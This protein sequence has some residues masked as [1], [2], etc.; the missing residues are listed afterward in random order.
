MSRLRKGQKGGEMV[1]L[2]DCPPG[3]LQHI[4]RMSGNADFRSLRLVIPL[5]YSVKLVFWLLSVCTEAPVASQVCK[6]LLTAVDLQMKRMRPRSLASLQ[7]NTFVSR[8]S[9]I[10]CLYVQNLVRES[11]AAVLSMCA[12]LPNLRALHGLTPTSYSCPRYTLT[13]SAPVLCIIV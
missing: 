11:D 13:S 9:G 5:Q 8:F 7:A 10:E 4:V 1:T 3:V 6:Q 12:A 2:A